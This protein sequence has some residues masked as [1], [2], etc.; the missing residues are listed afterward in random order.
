MGSLGNVRGAARG[1]SSCAV[2]VKGHTFTGERSRSETGGEEVLSELTQQKASGL[3]ERNKL[4][5]LRRIKE[6]ASELF[7]RKGFDDTTTREIASRP[8]ARHAVIIRTRA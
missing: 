3:R 1:F 7:V 5:K 6:A 8:L 2:A 4:D